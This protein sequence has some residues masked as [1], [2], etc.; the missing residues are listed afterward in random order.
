[1]LRNNRKLILV[2]L[3]VALAGFLT[4]SIG[5]ELLHSHIHHHADKASHDRC[6]ITLLQA[7]VFLTILGIV[8][9]GI[10]RV[11]PHFS[12]VSAPLFTLLFLTLP[13]L[14]APPVSR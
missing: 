12:Q 8:L 4:I 5:G 6:S 2:L 1:M 7:Q 14:R 3:F 10:V 11:V 13:N 9:A